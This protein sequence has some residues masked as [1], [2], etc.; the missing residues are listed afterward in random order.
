MAKQIEIWRPIP[1]F[2]N[3]EASTFGKIRSL[4]REGALI[5]KQRFNTSGYLRINLIIN[6]KHT[7]TLVHRL[8]ALAFLPNHDNKPQ[9]NHKDSNRANNKLSNLEWCTPSEN[10]QHAHNNGRV[11][12]RRGENH[13]CSVFTDSQVVEIKRRLNNGEGQSDLGREY[14]VSNKTIHNIHKETRWKHLWEGL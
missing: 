8:V 9:V 13:H 10:I 7:A 5:L 6:K 14:G 12:V 3:Y 4:K 1:G 11:A 2:D